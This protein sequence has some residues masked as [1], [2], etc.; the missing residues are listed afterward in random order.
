MEDSEDF[1][2]RF[3]DDDEHDMGAPS[4]GGSAS[5]TAA[6]LA[7]RRKLAEQER[8]MQVRPAGTSSCFI[9]RWTCAVGSVLHAR[10]VTS[11]RF[12][13]TRWGCVDFVRVLLGFSS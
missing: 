5:T 9:S 1:I 12:L 7:L 8:E 2:V 4:G 6:T 13:R 3:D 11:A 10:M